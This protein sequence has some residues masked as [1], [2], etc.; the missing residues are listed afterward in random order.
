MCDF[1]VDR[2]ELERDWGAAPALLD[3]LFDEARR[4][5]DGFVKVDARGLS[6]LTEGR[7]LTRMIARVFDAYAM[8]KAGHSSAV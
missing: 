1:R 8:D 7:P 6:V 4:G 3:R 2:E 5:F